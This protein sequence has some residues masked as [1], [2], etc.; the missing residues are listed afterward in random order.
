[1]HDFIPISKPVFS[2]QERVNILDCIDSAWISS[3]G[4]YVPKFESMNADYYGVKHGVAV[5]NGTVALHL[6]LAALGIG[7]GDEV[8][9]P[10][11]TFAATANAVFY[12]GAEPILADVERDSWT[13]DI[14]KCESL[15]SEKTKAIIP[16]HLYGQPC[17]M[18]TIL[19]FAQKYRLA[20]IEDCA[21]AHGAAFKGQKVGSF[22]QISCFSFYANKIVTTGEGGICLTNDDQLNERM[23]ILRDHGM[24]PSKRYWHDRIGYNY[25]MTNLQA[26]VGCAQMEHIDQSIQIRD[27]IFEQYTEILKNHPLLEIQNELKNRRKVCWLYSI[28]INTDKQGVDIESIQAALKDRNIDSRPFFVPLHEM[29]PYQK[30][31]H[32]ELNTAVE[33]YQKGISLPTFINLKKEE[34]DYIG[35]SL[36]NILNPFT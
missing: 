12:T 13:I 23:C 22:G 8:I 18:D 25:R 5:P 14:E 19:A 15:V 7:I 17:Q 3:A 24:H 1:M 31:R 2:N 10:D 16:V 27:E 32:S 20:I 21:E 4:P 34:V 35:S 29:P 28:L 11:L 36:V 33:V 26:A 30:L 6:A 9:V